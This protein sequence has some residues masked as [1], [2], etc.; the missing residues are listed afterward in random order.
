MF[1]KLKGEEG[2]SLFDWVTFPPTPITSQ[3]ASYTILKMSFLIVGN[4][5]VVNVEAD[6]EAR[7]EDDAEHIYP[8]GMI[9]QPAD[10]CLNNYR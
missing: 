4:E 3:V 2:K 5:P 1:W 10:P 6:K 8:S 9:K 7:E